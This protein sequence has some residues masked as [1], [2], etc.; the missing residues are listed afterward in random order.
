MPPAVVLVVPS[1]PRDYL[2]IAII[3]GFRKNLL[4]I[5]VYLINCLSKQISCTAAPLAGVFVSGGVMYT[6][7]WKVGMRLLVRL[8]HSCGDQKLYTT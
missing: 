5:I 7:L 1:H 3:A 6:R 8:A 2:K 4:Y